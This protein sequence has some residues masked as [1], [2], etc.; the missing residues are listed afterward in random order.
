MPKEGEEVEE[1]PWRQQKKTKKNHSRD[2][3]K[4]AEEKEGKEEKELLK[5]SWTSVF[6][7]IG[8]GSG[9]GDV[10]SYWLVSRLE[11]WFVDAQWW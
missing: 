9:V 2:H 7:L 10:S 11:I 8:I 4:Q 5:T 3:G 1:F 6:W